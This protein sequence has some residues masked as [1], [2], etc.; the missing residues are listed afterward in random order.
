MVLGGAGYQR[1]GKR[2][3]T[4]GKAITWHTAMRPGLRKKSGVDR[5]KEKLIGCPGRW[6]NSLVGE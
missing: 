6:S 3:E 2:A 1:V 4:V 5:Y